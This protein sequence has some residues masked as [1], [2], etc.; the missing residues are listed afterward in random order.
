M[1]HLVEIIAFICSLN[2]TIDADFRSFYMHVQIPSHV[3]AWYQSIHNS[4][5]T[6]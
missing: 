1:T 3:Y 5:F 6:D 4:K 2:Y